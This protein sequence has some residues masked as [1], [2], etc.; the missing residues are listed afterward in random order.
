MRNR[1]NALLRGQ[2]LALAAIALAG[3]GEAQGQDKKDG[4]VKVTKASSPKTGE[5]HILG[6]YVRP[7]GHT[8]TSVD[9]WL[10]KVD[11]FGNPVGVAIVILLDVHYNTSD[12]TITASGSG[13]NPTGGYVVYIR[14]TYER[15]GNTADV[16][17]D[18]SKAFG[19]RIK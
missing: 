11:F 1:G 8:V 17:K 12:H 10:Q 15:I 9:V 16:K 3:F 14:M 19:V 6:K 13:I 2:F 4:E 5:V 7:K 18:I